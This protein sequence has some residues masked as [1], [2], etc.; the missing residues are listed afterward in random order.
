[1]IGE[2][3]RKERTGRVTTQVP[4]DVAT[5]LM[6]EKREQLRQIEVRDK[7]SLVIV[8]NPHMHTP[9]YALRRIRDDEKELPEN[10][11]V[12]YQLA[13]QPVVEDESIG[14]RDKKPIGETPLV[15]SIVPTATAPIIPMPVP[16]PP[17]VAATPVPVPEVPQV[18]A[19]VRLWRWLFGSGASSTSATAS[20][21]VSASPPANRD[22]PQRDSRHDRY[23]S[24]GDRNRMHGDRDRGDRDRN[25]RREGAGRDPR[26][27]GRPPS[28]P[29]SARNGGQQPAQR[30]DQAPRPEAMQRSDVPRE[31][32][33]RN[34]QAQRVD[35]PRPDAA[36]PD[37]ARPD[38]ARPEGSDRNERGG[39]RGG[40]SR[41]R[42]GRG[43][44][45][46]DGG[47]GSV[48]GNGS[49][50]SLTGEGNTGGDIA[51]RVAD[52]AP[53]ST[54]SDGKYVVWSSAPSDVPRPGPEEH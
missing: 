8:P 36:R 28:R 22:R 31:Q 27:D 33:P 54:G 46:R 30:S 41:R 47:E 40:R 48:N 14:T 6:N 34:E 23:R 26:R 4:V 52:P 35:N 53:A 7:V 21:E 2:E 49:G 13:E 12:S 11:T 18:G 25:V 50:S 38:A 44:G 45:P 32:T 19:L 51:P 3:A 15:P 5:Y 20:A 1:L 10:S 9:A 17:P 29:D 42:R 37:A 16:A 39:E 24:G 43:R